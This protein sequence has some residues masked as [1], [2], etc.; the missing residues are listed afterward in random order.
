M[1]PPIEPVDPP[2]GDIVPRPGSCLDIGGGRWLTTTGRVIT[3]REVRG[4]K[5]QLA[6]NTVNYWERVA[7]NAGYPDLNDL[8]V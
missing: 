1:L 6:D 2:T 8:M 7:V 4:F 3:T 5:A